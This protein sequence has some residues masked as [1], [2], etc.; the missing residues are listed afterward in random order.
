MF[1]VGARNDKWVGGLNV[2]DQ[3]RKDS[4]GSGTMS[5]FKSMVR[6]FGLK[7]TRWNKWGVPAYAGKTSVV[8]E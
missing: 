4:L 5:L 3:V 6:L 2:A 1:Q 7:N 8:G